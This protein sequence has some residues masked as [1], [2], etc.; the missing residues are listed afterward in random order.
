MSDN[1]QRR[2]NVEAWLQKADQDI[3][4]ADRL[5]AGADLNEPRVFHCQQAVEKYLKGMLIALDV[6]PERTHDIRLLLQACRDVGIADTSRIMEAEIL[7]GFAVEARYP[8]M[9]PPVTDDLA[10]SARRIAG[11]VR[12]FVLTRLPFS[13]DD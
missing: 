2:V 5:P 3:R 11:E 8:G 12:D 9:G 6:E 13:L 1:E 4:A 10:E 7:S